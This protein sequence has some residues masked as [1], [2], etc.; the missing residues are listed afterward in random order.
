MEIGEKWK[1]KED[2]VEVKIVRIWQDEKEDEEKMIQVK[3]IDGSP[4]DFPN[5]FESEFPRYFEKKG[6]LL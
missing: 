4:N 1:Y 2:G 3:T 6:G 5:Y